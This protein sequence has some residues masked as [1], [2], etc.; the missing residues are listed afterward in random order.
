MST[1]TRRRAATAL[2][3]LFAV[4]LAAC[5]VADAT[6]PDDGG[7]D[8]P[9]SGGTVPASV[10]GGWRYGSVSP[11]TFWDDHTGLYSGS[12]YGMSDQYEFAANGTFK[13]YIYIYTQSYGCKIQAWVEMQGTVNFDASQFT[14]RVTSGRFRTIDTCA[15]SNNKDR[16]MS[17]SEAAERS[18][19]NAYVLK[20]DASGK[21]YMQILDGRY[22]RAQ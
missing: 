20:A 8:I 12:A 11:T 10:V 9:A 15:S 3:A 5:T 22:D 4:S 1:N 13:E 2:A 18:K 17:S 14:T 19:T 16:A 6:S 7:T 21:T